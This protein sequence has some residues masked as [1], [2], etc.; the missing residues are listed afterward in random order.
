MFRILISSTLALLLATPGAFA[1]SDPILDRQ[2]LMEETRDAAK[3]VGGMLKG[4]QPFDAEAAMQAFE[5]W[6]KTAA[7]VGELFPEGSDSGHDTEAK[8]TI[9]SDRAGFD[10]ELESF[11]ASVD[12][13]IAAA[14]D[15]VEALK[16]AAGPVFGSC[17][18]CHEGYRVEK[19]N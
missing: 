17:K 2:Q 15:S 16:A 7:K 3:T 9:W 14:P 13:A 18:D 11:A 8:A 4:A 6:K 1:E 10:R 12:A 5:A 19:E